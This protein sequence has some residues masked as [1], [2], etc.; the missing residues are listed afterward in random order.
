MLDSLLDKV[1]NWRDTILGSNGDDSQASGMV[2]SLDDG[3]G[4]C[5]STEVLLQA[6][7]A[8]SEISGYPCN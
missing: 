7:N 8:P 1:V 4:T 3:T 5:S 6:I 2:S